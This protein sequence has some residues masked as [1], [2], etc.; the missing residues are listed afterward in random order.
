MEFKNIELY[1]LNSIL[2]ISIIGVSLILISNIIFYPSDLISISIEITIL[3][4]CILAYFLRHKYAIASVL[5]VTSITIAAVSYQKWMSPIS[6]AGIPTMLIIG[7]IVSV[8]L[9]GKTMWIMHG[10]SMLLLIL[11]FA[12]FDTEPITSSVT[13][14]TIYFVLVFGAYKIKSAYDDFK[15]NLTDSNEVLQKQTLKMENQNRE[16]QATQKQLNELNKELEKRVNER[17]HRIKDQNQIL[18][19]YAYTNAHHL[20]GPVARLMGLASVYRLDSKENAEEIIDMMAQEAKEID[21][22]IKQINVDLAE[23]NLENLD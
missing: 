3:T 2:R 8:M 18:I 14:L 13:Y 19:R 6:T 20:R 21:S 9:K 12:P 7:F 23:K 11:V 16:L 17:T 1:F 10:L 15:R 22:V 4:A 5:I